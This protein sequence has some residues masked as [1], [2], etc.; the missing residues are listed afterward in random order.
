[1]FQR[2]PAERRASQVG[3]QDDAGR[4]DDRAQRVGQ[5]L[6]QPLLHRPRQLIEP[7]PDLRLVEL[8]RGDVGAQLFQHR[9]CGRD[10]RAAAFALNQGLDRRI[11]QQF[12]ERRQQAEQGGLAHSFHG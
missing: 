2:R 6:S 1:M 8:A 11:A 12:V 10:G 7:R 4:V 5:R 9:A 3:V